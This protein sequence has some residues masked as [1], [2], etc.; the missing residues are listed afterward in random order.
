MSNATILCVDDEHNVL[1]TLRTQLLRHFPG[2]MI[3]IAESG[4]EALALV[5]SLVAEGV[6]VP[7]V[8]ADHI[9][10]GMKG[11]ELLIELH[12]RYPQMLKV[13][14]TG[15]ARAEDVG[16]VVNQGNL[17]R[18]IAK[19][20]SE[21]DL[22]LTVTEALRRY[23][24][25]QQIAQQQ[26]ALEQANQALAALNATL[27]QSNLELL[28]ATKLKDEFLATVSHELRT[29]INA[30]LGMSECLQEEIFGAINPQ[31]E[32][33]LETIQFSGQHLLDVINDILDAST[34]ATGKLELTI[35][36]VAITELC[37]ASLAAV[38]QQA[39]QKQIQLTA[40]CS[41]ELGA[42]QVDECRMRQVL[43]NL[44]TNAIKFTPSGG[45]V[46][47]AGRLESHAWMQFSVSDTGI[48]IAP[49][50]HSKLFQSFMQ[51]D[52]DLNRQY[53]GTG[54]GLALVKQIVELHSGSVSLAS[55]LGEGSCFTVRLPYPAAVTH[56]TAAVQGFTL[57]NSVSQATDQAAD[58]VSGQ[59]A[60]Q[61][62]DQA[63]EAGT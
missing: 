25:D 46:S 15:Q 63:A 22:Q 39:I 37:A 2:Y 62:L 51:L 32:Q 17:Y 23:Q 24:Q 45:R 26:L 6:E 47:L 21:V 38:K 11:D 54:L 41:P 8:I 43:V 27:E 29:P 44:L 4:A 3:E 7:L 61:S 13:M 58:R 53:E 60:N 16:N 34:L 42:L 12:A 30:I 40:T 28:Q 20:W 48:G 57:P 31:Q 52:S 5:E 19:P 49:A 36:P 56:P 14:L 35:A 55:Q 18:F 50:D 10:P 59:G 9:M 33:A 1:L